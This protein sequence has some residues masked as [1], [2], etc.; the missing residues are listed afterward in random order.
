MTLDLDAAA[1]SWRVGPNLDDNLSG[2]GQPQAIDIREVPA[3]K[4]DGNRSRAEPAF[5]PTR[6]GITPG[7]RN[8]SAA[9]SGKPASLLRRR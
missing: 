8:H 2:V 6:Q 7:K 4:D 1:D 9:S 5:A 3:G